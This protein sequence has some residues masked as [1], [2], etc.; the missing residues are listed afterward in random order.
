MMQH[1][2][3]IA[4]IANNYFFYFINYSADMIIIISSCLSIPST[5]ELRVARFSGLLRAISLPTNFCSRP[6]LAAKRNFLL[7]KIG[8]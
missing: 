4:L 6:Q 8:Q 2:L 3:E 7:V 5:L 1:V